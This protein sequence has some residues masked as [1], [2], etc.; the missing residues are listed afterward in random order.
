MGTGI[1]VLRGFICLDRRYLGMPLREAIWQE[2]PT[3]VLAMLASY[4]VALWYR[5]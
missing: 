5:R 2:I 1:L 3:V 4:P